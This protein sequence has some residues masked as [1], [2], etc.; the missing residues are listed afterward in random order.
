MTLD[1]LS[2]TS[3][4]ASFALSGVLKDLNFWMALVVLVKVDVISESLKLIS[5]GGGDEAGF[6]LSE[7][8]LG[9]LGDFRGIDLG[10]DL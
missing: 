5:T 10:F 7:D 1:G 4:L 9:L 6:C 8:S 2:P 3:P